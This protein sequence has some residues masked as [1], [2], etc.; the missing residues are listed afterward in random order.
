MVSGRKPGADNSK[1]Y[2]GGLIEGQSV[3]RRST[4]TP[5]EFPTC[6]LAPLRR[7]LFFASIHSCALW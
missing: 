7:G 6:R 3:G 5:P 2:C 1:N 4:A